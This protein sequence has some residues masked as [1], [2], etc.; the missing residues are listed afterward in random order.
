[1]IECLI[2]IGIGVEI[3]LSETE[4]SEEQWEEMKEGYV[5]QGYE[6][7]N[8]SERDDKL[9]ID[10][11]KLYVDL[12]INEEDKIV[13]FPDADLQRD[14]IWHI[15]EFG[16]LRYTTAITDQISKASDEYIDTIELHKGR[17]N[18]SKQDEE[19]Q[20]RA[21]CFDTQE[22]FIEACTNPSIDGTRDYIYDEFRYSKDA[23]DYVYEIQQMFIEEFGQL[24]LDL[25]QLGMAN[26]GVEK[27]EDI[28][29]LEE[30]QSG[31]REVSTQALEV[32]IAKAKE[33]LAK[34]KIAIPCEDLVWK[35]LS[36]RREG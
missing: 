17:E 7:Y 20:Y 34:N 13:F 36:M 16:A 27:K 21:W 23:E 14:V 22:E 6:L 3:Y 12:S 11:K 8:V 33:I 28:I 32:G 1:M 2:Y 19:K 30:Y 25:C 15:K 24:N 10:G 5:R 29:V 9:I 18:P 31:A 35:V 4:Y 26:L